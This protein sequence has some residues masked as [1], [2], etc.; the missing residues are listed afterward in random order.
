MFNVICAEI[1]STDEF[2]DLLRR[3]LYPFDD[4]E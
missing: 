1:K 3:V 2:Q 4:D